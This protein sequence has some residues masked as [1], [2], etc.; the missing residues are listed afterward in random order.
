MNRLK[1]LVVYPAR[2]GFH[3]VSYF[4]C[5]YGA[6]KHDFTYLGLAFAATAGCETSSPLPGVTVKHHSCQSG[7]SGRSKV[8]RLIREEVMA[9]KYDVV[10]T[11]YIPGFSL[12]RGFFARQNVE[13]I[14]DIRSGFLV[15]N[16]CKRFLLNRML[17]YEC[18]KFHHITINSRLLG[19]YLGFAEGEV[20][21]LPLGAEPVSVAPQ[22]FDRLHLLYVGALPK[23]Q[24][25]RTV[26]GLRLYINRCGGE[27]VKQYDIVGAGSR[28]DEQKIRAAIV[29]NELEGVV[30]MH[31]YV[32]RE[33]MAEFLQ[34]ANVGVSFVPL[35]PYYDM[36]PVTKTYEYLM[37]GLPIIATRTTQNQRLVNDSNGV[38]IDDTPESFSRGL[39]EI[40]SKLSGLSPLVIQGASLQHS[41]ENVIR[42]QYLP[43][44]ES[45]LRSDVGPQ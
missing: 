33:R 20:F 37:A 35:T 22:D 9:G 16:R 14:V 2:F 23:R 42:G 18:R 12:L 19:K 10:F 36:Q 26:A 24:V 38:L 34:S 32:P 3:V 4:L 1:V 28:E 6:Q 43:Y 40:K 8:L 11:A 25:E 21:E 17:R 27:N 29:E 7:L 41:W 39:A 31:G 30:K 44:M 13:V 15:Q 45:L 5:K